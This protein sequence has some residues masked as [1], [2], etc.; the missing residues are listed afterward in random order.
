MQD[1]TIEDILYSSAIEIKI[2]TNNYAIIMKYIVSRFKYEDNCSYIIWADKFELKRL[3]D[4]C[5]DLIDD[6]YYSLKS[7]TTFDQKNNYINN[8]N[9]LNNII[10]T[11]SEY[12]FR[13]S[14]YINTE[15]FCFYNPN[16]FEVQLFGFQ[17]GENTRLI[18]VEPTISLANSIII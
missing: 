2:P 8:N 18:I 17:L 16:N 3:K 12:F 6:D 11:N 9:N 10:F 4:I 5:L 1:K 14:Y 13:G 15:I 7:I